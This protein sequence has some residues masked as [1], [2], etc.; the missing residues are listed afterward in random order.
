MNTTAHAR[1]LVRCLAFLA[2]MPELCTDIHSRNLTFKP[3]PIT[4]LSSKEVSVSG[5]VWLKNLWL[6]RRKRRKRKEEEE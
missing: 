4:F 3:V 2:S 5:Q 1:D 6:K